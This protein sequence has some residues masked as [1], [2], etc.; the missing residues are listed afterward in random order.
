MGTRFFSCLGCKAEYEIKGDDVYF[1]ERFIAH[2]RDIQKL[3]GGKIT[4]RRC[5]KKMTI[6][7]V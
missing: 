3:F 7:G 4:C 5:G 6:L 2:L 1:G